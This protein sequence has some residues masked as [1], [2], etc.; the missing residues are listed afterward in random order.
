MNLRPLVFA[1]L[2]FFSFSAWSQVQV[3]YLAPNPGAHSPAAQN[4]REAILQDAIPGAR[5]SHVSQMGPQVQQA[6]P[7]MAAPGNQYPQ[8]APLMPQAGI[9]NPGQEMSETTAPN[10]GR[11]M[12]PSNL[13]RAQ[14]DQVLW[15]MGATSQSLRQAGIASGRGDQSMLSIATSFNPDDRRALYRWKE[16]LPQFGVDPVKITF[17]SRR[18]SR[19]SFDAW[20][21]RFVWEACGGYSITPP[22]A[23]QGLPV[24]FSP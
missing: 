2:A 17:E 18:L 3:D 9:A 13:D 4:A 15:E 14:R 8:P 5:V 16:W 24:P 6:Y 23:C 10:E 22:A 21:S 19:S 20:A 12:P 1:S 7:S 11:E